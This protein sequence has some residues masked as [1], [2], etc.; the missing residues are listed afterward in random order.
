MYDIDRYS[1]N[2]KIAGFEQKSAILFLAYMK[3][4]VISA[5]SPKGDPS[6]LTVAL[7]CKQ[8][9]FAEKIDYMRA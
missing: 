2:D 3:N 9:S 1:V 8:Q 5:T 7:S 6:E 4:I